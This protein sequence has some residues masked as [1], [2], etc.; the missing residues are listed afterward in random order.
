MGW[1]GSYRRGLILAAAVLGFSTIAEAAD[2]YQGKTIKIIC[3]NPVAGSIDLYSRL[4]ARFMPKYIPGNPNIIVQQMEG[5]GG[6]VA[7]N[8]I[9]T[10]AEKDSLVIGSSNSG[11]AFEPLLGAPQAKYDATKFNWLGSAASPT[12]MLTVWHTV[13]VKNLEDGRN[14]EVVLGGGGGTT[15]IYSSLIKSLFDLKLKFISGYSNPVAML[16]MERGEIDGYPNAFWSTLK[17]NYPHWLKDNKLRFLVQFGAINP[18]V[19]EAQ[20]PIARKLLK[21]EA[22]RQVMDLGSGPLELGYPFFMPPGVPAEHVAIIRKALAATFADPEFRAEAVKTGLD[23]DE[24]PATG[25][26]L[27]AI[28]AK[29]YNA[30]APVKE[31]FLAIYNSTRS[32]AK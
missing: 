15:A 25:E 10:Q 27:S 23:V 29:S 13:P 5:A 30:P 2:F 26:D 16:A 3:N 17:A 6:I 18:E 9:Y 14:R 20:V 12:A 7:A 24:K 22:D 21:T 4:V 28:L 11:M 31:R 1:F 8:Y 19:P 32:P